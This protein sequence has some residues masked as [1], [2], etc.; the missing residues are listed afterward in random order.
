MS[1]TY[2][3]FKPRRLPLSPAELSEESVE[4]LTDLDT[5]KAALNSVIPSLEWLP[6]GW[7]RGETQEG[8]WVE[9]NIATP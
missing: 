4:T 9:F 6:Q 3:F 2:L 5:V 1:Y 8:N 7:A